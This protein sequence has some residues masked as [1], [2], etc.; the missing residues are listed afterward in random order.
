MKL[1]VNASQVRVGDTLCFA[2]PSTDVRVER[3]T[4]ARSNGSIGMHGN[5][6]TWTSFYEPGHR[7][8]ILRNGEASHASV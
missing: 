4:Q 1:Y 5:N 8:R 2:N 6:D 7:V 3:V